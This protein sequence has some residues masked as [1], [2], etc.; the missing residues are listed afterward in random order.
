MQPVPQMA[1]TQ[2]LRMNWTCSNPKATH[3][4]QTPTTSRA[5]PNLPRQEIPGKTLLNKRIRE[6]LREK[7]NAN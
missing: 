2:T 3:V 5:N 6:I 7:F 1:A 4:N